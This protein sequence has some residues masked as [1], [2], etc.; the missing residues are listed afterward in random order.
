MSFPAATRM[1]RFAALFFLVFSMGIF[2]LS[3]FL[4]NFSF[5]TLSVSLNDCWLG[6][7]DNLFGCLHSLNP[8][9]Y[10]LLTA[11]II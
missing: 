7:P 4:I 6:I 5:L 9:Q 1:F 8:D 2:K 3:F 10:I 11:E